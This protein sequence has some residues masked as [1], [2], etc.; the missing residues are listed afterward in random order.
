MNKPIQ[1]T[2]E[3]RSQNRKKIISYLRR[4]DQ[5]TKKDI[6]KALDL[7]VATVS[8]LGNQLIEEGFLK[9]SA[10]QNSNGG[11]SSGLLSLNPNSQYILGLNMANPDI[12]EVGIMNLRNEKI[13]SRQYEAPGK[14]SL[15]TIIGRYKECSTKILRETGIKQDDLL[16]IGV[17]APG[18]IN[19]ENGHLLNSTNKALEDKPVLQALTREFNTAV[20]IEN[21]SNLLA[22]AASLCGHVRDPLQDVVYIYME[23]GLG[24]GIICNG[25]LVTG[26]TGFG[27]EVNHFPVG[28]RKYECW[29]GQK[30]CIETE[31]TMEGFLRKYAHESGE[32]GISTE[33]SWGN[34]IRAIKHD[35]GHAMAV[36]SENG[37][38]LG[39][40]SAMVA[41]IFEPESIF[42]GGITD[43]FFD[44]IQPHIISEFTSRSVLN[45]VKKINITNSVNFRELI[46]QGCGELVYSN[47]NP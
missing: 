17:A 33:K 41:S 20:L 36:L 9:I 3:L 44:K 1:N 37:K 38:L 31:L 10:Y 45:S 26:R 43:E 23:K 14:G 27:G 13:Q 30:G 8:S 12:V 2:T 6:A 11:R 16:G 32:N 22:L 7:S 21:E 39:Q 47:W 35:N 28:F 18:I 42:I 29:C 46:F 34:F 40:I 5:A 25:R 4:T 19:R 24:I 15:E